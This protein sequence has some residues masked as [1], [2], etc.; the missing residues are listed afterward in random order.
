MA[1]R[2]SAYCTLPC[3]V[4]PQGARVYCVI[5]TNI[6]HYIWC[7]ALLHLSLTPAQGIEPWNKGRQLSEET[8]M[9]MRLAKLNRTASK[10]TRRRMSEAHRGKT[11]SQVLGKS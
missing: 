3:G 11:H 4:S 5:V 7:G 10:S 9:K 8:R 2:P 6:S 1:I